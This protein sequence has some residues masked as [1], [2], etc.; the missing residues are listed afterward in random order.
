MVGVGRPCFAG[1]ERVEKMPLPSKDLEYLRLVS[2]AA[3]ANPFGSRR[4]RLDQQ[5]SGRRGDDT[6]YL[7]VLTDRV[8]ERLAEI[9]NAAS[10]TELSEDETLLLRSAVA[11]EQFHRF[12]VPMD[13]LIRRQLR[14][15]DVVEVPFARDLLRGLIA[16]G[17][18]AERAEHLL[19]LF[20]QMRRAW[21]FIDESLVGSS[22]SMQALREGLWNAVFTRD[23][24]RY[25][26]YLHNKMEDFSTLL[27][28]ETGTGKGAAA[29]AVGRSAYIS[30]D[31][32]KDA[33][34]QHFDDFF[35]PIN[36]SQF[37]ESLLESELFGHKKGAFTGA[38][39][40][41]TGVF[42]RCQP[43]GTILLD[44]IGELHVTVQIKL[45]RV[46]QDRVFSPVGSH[47]QVRFEGRVL[48]AT[49]RTLEA[50][51][52]PTGF[53]DDFYYRLS[54]HHVFMP[55]LRVRLAEDPAELDRLIE[56]L[57]ARL[58]G[59]KT[60][61]REL[62]EELKGAIHRDTG[63]GYGW[64]G[65]VRELE[66]AIR[67]V[68]LTGSCVPE[69]TAGDAARSGPA[70]CAGTGD[71]PEDWVASVRRGMMTA[72][73]LLQGYCVLLHSQLGTFAEVARR[74]ELDRRTVK[75]Y[76]EQANE[77]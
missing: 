56:S 61:P 59:V 63:E 28:G 37:S 24:R 53:R 32:K 48:A 76:I 60:A 3:F 27:L 5:L 54:S 25:E 31:A 22:P 26:S 72:E 11:F 74:T 50:L 45:L 15:Q 33:F 58:L 10:R 16:G 38:I 77:A 29:S 52:S 4:V 2:E 57:L 17:F 44:E 42:G 47:Q 55:P 68:L 34:T 35:V 7:D 6:T 36:L 23:V 1:E 73:E 18:P 30:F 65:N 14:E 41:Y 46:L 71:A 19:A 62:L 64:P 67:R 75:K 40:A 39:E 9:N 43:R 21:F 20:Y 8:S 49:N 12:V 51:R 66:Q 70:D 13:A 69:V